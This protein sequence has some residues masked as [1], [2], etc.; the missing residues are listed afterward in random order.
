LVLRWAVIYP[1]APQIRIRRLLDETHHY[2]SIFDA[3][4]A[5][6]EQLRRDLLEIRAQRALVRGL[7]AGG[8]VG[9][10][11]SAALVTAVIGG[12]LVFRG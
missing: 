7:I 11:L 6:L 10:A 12:Y 5:F 3:K 1:N 4:L 9:V 8:L 2:I